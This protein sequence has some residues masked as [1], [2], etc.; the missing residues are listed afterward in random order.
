METLSRIRDLFVRQQIFRDGEADPRVYFDLTDFVN[1][2]PAQSVTDIASTLADLSPIAQCDAIVSIADRC[3]GAIAHEAARITDLPYTLAN[4]YPEGMPGEIEVEN[5]KGFSGTGQVWLNGLKRNRRVVILL[6]ILRTGAT[7]ANL[8]RACNRAGCQVL[9]V[10]FAAELVEFNGR[11]L[12]QEAFDGIQI[13]SAVRVHVRGERTSEVKDSEAIFG[14]SAAQILTRKLR[15][16]AANPNATDV[17]K[18]E[19]ALDDPNCTP[20]QLRQAAA[21]KSDPTKP[22]RLM[23]ESSVKELTSLITN[24]FVGI[25]ITPNEK[26]GGYP[27]SFF[28]LTDFS[29]MMT[30]NI[31]EA[32]ADLTV[33]FGAFS[34]CDVIVAEADRGGAPIAQAVARRTKLPFVLANWYPLGEGMGA[35]TEA[36][37]GF[38]GD[39]SMVLNGVRRGDRCIFVDDMLSSGGTAEGVLGSIVKLGGI[40]LQGVFASEKLYPPKEGASMPWRKGKD[41]L[42]GPYPEFEVITLCQFI[43]EGQRTSAPPHPIG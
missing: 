34:R 10:C 15:E 23:N 20:A 19:A 5:C 42:H 24:A 26:L 12:Q 39:G 41:R 2:V 18:I 28:Q 37:V 1:P 4:W 11:K 3:C 30:P 43:A 35:S 16:G 25:P 7:A 38:S 13:N 33:H 22:F 21:T 8:I 29:P 6:D 17:A 40:P 32:M 14:P 9:A 27:Y 36:S 31:V